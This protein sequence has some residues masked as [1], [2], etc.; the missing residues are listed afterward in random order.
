MLEKGAHIRSTPAAVAALAETNRALPALPLYC[1]A[2]F[3]GAFLLFAVQPM[4]TKMILPL[5]GGTPAVWNTAVM[6]FQAMLLAGYLYAHL[7]SRLSRLRWQVL[8]HGSVLALGLLS[9]PIHPAWPEAPSSGIPPV[10]W[11]VGLL[12]VSIGLPFFAVSATA[13]LLQR[14]F[15][16]SDHPQASDPYFLYVSSNIGGLLALL[17]YPVVIEP[18]FGLRLQSRAWAAG[19]VLLALTIALCSASLWTRRKPRSVATQKPTR[20]RDKTVIPRLS[21]EITWERRIHWIVLAFVPSALL[22]AV[23]LHISTDVAAAPF[24]W[25]LPLSLYMLSFVIVFARRPILKHKWMLALQLV[26]YALLVVYFT[27]RS[28]L[29][30]LGLHLLALF[31]TAMV[32]HGELVRN[33][34]AA[35]H[36]TEFYL[37][38]ST[39]GLL[40]GI[41][42]VLAAPL[43]FDSVL[44]YPL[45][46]TLACLLRPGST[47]G[48]WRRHLLDV[49][50]PALFALLFFFVQALLD[51]AAFKALDIAGPLLLFGGALLA[52][53]SFRHRP[54]RLALAFAPLIFGLIFVRDVRHQL[55]RRRS[56]F[57]VY[58][59]STDKKG[60]T[61]YLYHGN[62]IHGSQRMD[63]A[64]VSTPTGYYCEEGPL[65]QVFATVGTTR[66]LR[67]VGCIGLGTGTTACYRQ[68][69]RRVTFF[70]VDPVVER[71]ARDPSLFRYLDP[72]GQ[73]VEVILGDGRQS[74]SR[75][76]DGTFDLLILDAFSSDAIPAH[77]LTREALALYLRKSTPAAIIM[78]HISNRYV[79]LEPVV[80]GLVA[81]AGVSALIQDYE[82]DV[83]DTPTKPMSSQ[84]V[85]VARHES[86][87][88]CL[89]E[90][91]RWRP[92]EPDPRVGLWTDDC[93]NLFEI[94]TW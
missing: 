54:V 71:I 35:E 63:P 20:V 49:L 92:L 72:G 15:S 56:F 75:M 38:M 70:E 27:E 48:G 68:P 55:L 8:V 24:L 86:D 66:E 33:R 17:A 37:W 62:I 28:L 7:L 78:F 12:A 45:L 44:E 64:M 91:N 74:L 67:H 79:R 77:L 60:E 58:T 16:H 19:Y 10:L 51:F 81:D 11:L 30:L 83:E 25:V 42:C 89:K 47:A 65:G 52:F 21:G 31:V 43:L 34:P 14:W 26:V 6:F 32:C 41:F 36:L 13:P 73:D 5:L 90:D 57:G 61:H 88:A 87:L 85:A 76:P 53:W 50:L 18:L 84:W 40:G 1:T 69:G 82:P 2:L 23:T 46:L 39:G 59:V 80:A 4:F 3:L 93:S 29:P 22:L 94:L 9:V